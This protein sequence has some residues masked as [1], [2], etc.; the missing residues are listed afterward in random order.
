MKI[1]ATK[2]TIVELPGA[3][4]VTYTS[5]RISMALPA[6]YPFT[7]GT[8]RY[9]L[10]SGMLVMTINSSKTGTSTRTWQRIE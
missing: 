6:G 2:H 7:D 10:D 4:D 3:A 5:G 9:T 1:D 8:L